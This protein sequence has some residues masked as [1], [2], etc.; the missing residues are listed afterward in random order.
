[1]R[2]VL[3]FSFVCVLASC[4]GVNKILKS[5]DP[6]YKLR[7][8]EK[9]YVKK[10]YNYAYQ[11]FEDVVPYYKTSKEFEDIYY[12]MAYSTFYQKDYTN[13]ENFFKTYLELFPT[14]PVR[15]KWTL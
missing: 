9:Y 8:A 3:F 12:K 6:E 7:M 11:L 5:K 2:L 15:K 1:M 4:H 10:K 14:A 13:S